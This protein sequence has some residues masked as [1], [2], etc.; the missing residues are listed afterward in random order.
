MR[1]R[2]TPVTV[3]AGFGCVI[4]ADLGTDSWPPRSGP[5]SIPEAHLCRTSSNRGVSKKQYSSHN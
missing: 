2:F 5:R 4:T 1:L 3:V